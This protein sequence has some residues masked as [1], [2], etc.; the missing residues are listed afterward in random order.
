MMQELWLQLFHNSRE[1][2]NS[3]FSEIPKWQIYHLL[4]SMTT[5]NHSWMA[6][7]HTASLWLS[8]GY[9]CFLYST[10]FLATL[11]V[12]MNVFYSIFFI[13]GNQLVAVAPSVLFTGYG[14]CLPVFSDLWPLHISMFLKHCKKQ[15]R[16]QIF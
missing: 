5:K 4:Q 11:C 1:W 2:V 16:N 3:A 9:Q 12:T 14:Y 13:T 15:I 10:S 8:Q 7:K 6:H